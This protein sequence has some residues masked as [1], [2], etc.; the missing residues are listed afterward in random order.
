[1]EENEVGLFYMEHRQTLTK[2]L[3]RE[4]G[5]SKG[6]DLSKWVENERLRLV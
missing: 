3:L 5:K 4:Q 2:L 6:T 1:V